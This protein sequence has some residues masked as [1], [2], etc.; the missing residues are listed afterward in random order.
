MGCGA[1][2]LQ[3]PGSQ[4]LVHPPPR[5]EPDIPAAAHFEE[6]PEERALSTRKS[7]RNVNFQRQRTRRQSIGSRKDVMRPTHDASRVRLDPELPATQSIDPRGISQSMLD[8]SRRLHA[9][10]LRAA[11][12][13]GHRRSLEVPHGKG[14]RANNRSSMAAEMLKYRGAVYDDEALASQKSVGLLLEALG[15]ELGQSSRTEEYA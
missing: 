14:A 3:E 6:M 13:H 2:Q 10:R 4:V 8:R 12:G 7:A 1:S 11:R 5:D 15:Q 9:E